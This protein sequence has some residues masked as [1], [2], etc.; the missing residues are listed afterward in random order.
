MDARC[1]KIAQMEKGFYLKKHEDNTIK[2]LWV[3]EKGFSKK[4]HSSDL[5]AVEWLIQRG[6]PIKETA[7]AEEKAE[8]DMIRRDWLS[9]Y[10]APLSVEPALTD[11]EAQVEVVAEPDDEHSDGEH[12][13]PVVE[14]PVQQALDEGH[15]EP[16]GAPVVINLTH[17][18]TPEALTD[19]VREL[20]RLIGHDA[21]V[22]L[23]EGTAGSSPQ[24]SAQ[25]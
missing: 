25:S 23:I 9:V 6:C 22:R 8:A 3:H 21:F 24:S 10:G 19:T 5:A 14:P 4:V 16:S 7:S 20:E 17:E 11:G 15:Q 18:T 13:E 1:L 12:Y 2:T